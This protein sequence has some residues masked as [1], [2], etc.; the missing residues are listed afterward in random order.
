MTDRTILRIPIS[1]KKEDK[2]DLD[3]LKKILERQLN[4]TDLIGMELSY[5]EVMR[6]AI[7]IALTHTV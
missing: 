4:Q 2:E 6:R 1:L 7:Q 5:A 3:K